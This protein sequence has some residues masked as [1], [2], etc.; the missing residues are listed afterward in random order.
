V[1]RLETLR[2]GLDGGRPDQVD[3][4]RLDLADCSP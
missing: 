2:S 1:D 3:C 4:G